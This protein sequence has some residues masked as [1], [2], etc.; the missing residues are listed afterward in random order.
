MSSPLHLRA[1]LLQESSL[2][3]GSGHV[4]L[5][6]EGADDSGSAGAGSTGT[7]TGETGSTTGAT[8]H[9]L[10]VD[11][12]GWQLTPAGW[13]G[14]IL[15]ADA[16]VPLLYLP[17]TA[18]LSAQGTE[19]MRSGVPLQASVLDGGA[20]DLP[21]SAGGASSSSSNAATSSWWLQ[22]ANSLDQPGQPSASD[23]LLTVLSNYLALGQLQLARTVMEQMFCAAP[24]KLIRA[25]RAIVFTNIPAAWSEERCAAR[26]HSRR[27]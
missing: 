19:N 14:G 2:L 10:P 7:T 25:L 24:E 17:R 9:G 6:I 21:S 22:G 3:S 13:S 8:L 26:T 12:D 20:A 23:Q 5:R 1:S 16:S 15:G 27:R 11:N 4:D 18:M